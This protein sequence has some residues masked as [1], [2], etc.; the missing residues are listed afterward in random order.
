MKI[1]FVAT[2]LGMG[3]AE[4]QVVNLSDQLA[5]RGH[6]V[7]VAYLTGEVVVRPSVGAVKVVSLG[8][9][10]NNPFSFLVG[11]R[12]LVGLV[13]CFEPDV[14]HGHMFHANIL[15][16][17]ARVFVHMP[18]LISTAHNTDEGGRA[19]ML[20][21]RL[22][23]RLTDVFTNV[24]EEAVAAFEK[25]GA[26]TARG[27]VAVTNGV[28]TRRFYRDDASRERAREALCIGASERALV[29][30]GRLDVQK[31]YPNLLRAFARVHEARA[32]CRLFIVG[33]GDQAALLRQQVAGLEL[34]GCVSFL[35]VRHDIPDVLNAADVF[36]LS[37]RFEGFGLVVAEAMACERLVV[38]TDCG[39][40]R[41]VLGE[42][43]FLVPP[44]DSPA[45]AHALLA[46]MTRDEADGR[47]LG[48]LARQRVQD[49][50]SL[51]RAV[52]RWLEIYRGCLANEV[53]AS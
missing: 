18:M 1:L 14:V 3:G 37:S 2:S 27:M 43:G 41:E 21:Y 31:D 35:G 7:T 36:V 11:L 5:R 20:A 6:A 40:V 44:E 13:R 12:R 17:I 15:A 45:L 39:G 38:A 48:R 50:F 30:V 42:T 49:R 8:M 29:A 52:D 16:R 33:G 47:V 22:T 26:V 9:V 10:R 25:K 28:D 4:T 19:R 24:S 46:A 53:S 32:D 23:N 51:D 34:Q